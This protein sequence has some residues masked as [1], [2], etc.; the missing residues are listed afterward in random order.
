MNQMQM[1]NN[2]NNNNIN[3]NNNN[4]NSPRSPNGGFNTGTTSQEHVFFPSSFTGS[5][6]YATA[7]VSQN[8][9]S[10][11]VQGVL[12]G[13]LGSLAPP[14]TPLSPMNFA[15][16]IPQTSNQNIYAQ[17]YEQHQQN[18]Q[19]QQQ[20]Q[21]NQMAFNNAS[22]IIASAANLGLDLNPGNLN[23]IGTQMNGVGGQHVEQQ[24][25]LS[26]GGAGSLN[27][28]SWQGVSGQQSAAVMM[29]SPLAA[30]MPSGSG[31]LGSIPEQGNMGG[32]FQ[33]DIEAT[34][35]PE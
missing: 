22:Q 6:T 32:T 27:H 13:H 17:S 25:G 18:Q 9:S 30:S 15:L 21:Q 35:S 34:S 5:P 23:L 28:G 31:F 3:N 11:Q 14:M 33:F 2:N 4:N 16:Q 10:H 24:L 19:H 26:G 8:G 1:N 29:H 7:A 20:A 12:T